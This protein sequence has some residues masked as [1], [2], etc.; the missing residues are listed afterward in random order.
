MKIFDGLGSDYGW[1]FFINSYL[2]IKNTE[3]IENKRMNL[4]C[5]DLRK[6]DD[7]KGGKEQ[8]AFPKGQNLAA[9]MWLAV[10]TLWGTWQ[11]LGLRVF[12][13]Q[14]TLA[15][16]WR[17]CQAYLCL[18]EVCK[19]RHLRIK[20]LMGSSRLWKVEVWGRSKENVTSHWIRAKKRQNDIPKIIQMQHTN[21]GTIYCNWTKF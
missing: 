20:I 15:V 1:L 19:E 13:S 11:L 16:S 6:N 18:W 21:G 2:R 9:P 14:K 8:D 7:S 17:L 12:Y 5:L 4:I 3:E 10:S